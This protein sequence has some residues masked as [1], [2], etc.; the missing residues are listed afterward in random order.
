MIAIMFMK[1]AAKKILAISALI[2]FLA[3]TSLS[4]FYLARNIGHFHDNPNANVRSF[5]VFNEIEIPPLDS[6]DAHSD[7]CPICQNL[8]S[9]IAFIKQIQVITFGFAIV[10]IA[11]YLYK[12]KILPIRPLCLERSTLVSLNVISNT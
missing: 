7:N 1:G 10:F 4:M 12:I 11:A 8:N 6:S 3:S 9:A 5:W 2:I